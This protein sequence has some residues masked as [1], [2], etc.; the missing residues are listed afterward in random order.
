MRVLTTAYR[1]RERVAF[2][3]VRVQDKTATKL[4]KKYSVPTA[5]QTD[6]L[7]LFQEDSSSPGTELLAML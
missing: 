2:G 1:F 4:I 5:G 6:T 7:L 3:F